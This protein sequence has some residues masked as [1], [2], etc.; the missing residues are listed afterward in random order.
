M[1]EEKKP[2]HAS[3]ETIVALYAGVLPPHHE[4]W[5]EFMYLISH[6]TGQRCTEHNIPGLMAHAND[7]RAE[8]L[9]R[10]ETDEEIATVIK[11]AQKHPIPQGADQIYLQHWTYEVLKHFSS[12]I[13]IAV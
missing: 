5:G 8:L 1:S 9:R 12:E 6:L 2:F 10:A 4:K 3:I 13:P 7:A 11:Y